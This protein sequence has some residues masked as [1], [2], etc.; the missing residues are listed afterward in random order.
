MT[1]QL[2]TLSTVIFVWIDKTL[3]PVK[4]FEALNIERQHDCAK[5]DLVAYYRGDGTR[6]LCPPTSI[7][8]RR[9]LIDAIQVL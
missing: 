1:K 7:S 9:V 8:I 6:V 4:L 3:I 5:M 2:I